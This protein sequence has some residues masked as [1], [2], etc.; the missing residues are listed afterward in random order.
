LALTCAGCK[1]LP[2]NPFAAGE[3]SAKPYAEREQASTDA[4]N[5][6]ESAAAKSLD[7]KILE[8]DSWFEQVDSPFA[9]RCESFIHWH[10]HQLDPLLHL[11]ARNRP[12]FSGAQA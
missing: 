3:K 4:A 5:S 7:L 8:S 6:A 1:A 10:H 9:K 11:S 2:S 12:D